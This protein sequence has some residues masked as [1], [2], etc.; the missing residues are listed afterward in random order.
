MKTHIPNLVTC[1]N[2]FSG[3]LGIVFAFQGNFPL[4]VVC[5]LLSGVFDLFDGLVAR[6]LN[7]SSAIGKQLDSLADVISFGFLPGMIYY[8]LIE[9]SSTVLTDYPYIGFL[10]PIFSALRLAKFNLDERQTED[11]IGLNTPM[12]TF[13]T[14][15]LPFIALTFPQIIYTPWFLIGSIMVTSWLLISE[16][17]LFSMKFKDLS[18]AG[19]RFRYS[20]LAVSAALLVWLEFIAIPG[21]LI[22]YVLFSY[23]HFRF[24]S[25]KIA[26]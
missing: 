2:L 26:T 16:I 13:Y 25:Y 8:T 23:A 3:C 18:W 10:I 4:V 20:F 9:N 7:V 21:I 6:L 19:N 5:V 1:M 17:K 15:S 22:L 11:F 12:N 24:G 14:M